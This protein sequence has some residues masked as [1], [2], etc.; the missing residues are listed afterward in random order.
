MSPEAS[1]KTGVSVETPSKEAGEMLSKESVEKPGMTGQ[2]TKALETEATQERVKEVNGRRFTY[3]YRYK[4]GPFHPL[5]KDWLDEDGHSIEW[6]EKK[7]LLRDWIYGR[8]SPEEFDAHFPHYWGPPKESYRITKEALAM[9]QEEKESFGPKESDELHTQHYANNCGDGSGLPL[10][11]GMGPVTDE[12][13]NLSSKEILL[14]RDWVHGRMS[15]EEFDTHFPNY[16]GPKDCYR[17]NKEEVSNAQSPH[18]NE[19]DEDWTEEE[20]HCMMEDDTEEMLCD[21]Y[22]DCLHEE[23]LKEG[24]LKEND[25]KKPHYAHCYGDGSGLPLRP[26]MRGYMIEEDQGDSFKKWQAECES[27]G[28]MTDEEF[29]AQYPDKA[30]KDD[31]LAQGDAEELLEGGNDEQPRYAHSYGDGSGLPLRPG[32]GPPKTK[33]EQEE[34]LKKWEAE[35]DKIFNMSE[36]EFNAEF[37]GYKDIPVYLCPEYEAYR[38]MEECDEAD[39]R[40]RDEVLHKWKESIKARPED[41]V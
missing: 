24:S 28:N 36:E 33:E 41:Q 38:I 11:P 25:E 27:P 3:R 18:P 10:R 7:S 4:D 32:M 20:G 31:H 22:Y 9:P 35:D 19:S 16:N 13:K 26:G 17:Y 39:D 2:V 37:P 6:W 30:M 1:E 40:R 34:P 14:L 8:M 29:Y 23:R 12:Q 15:S 21:E 5:L